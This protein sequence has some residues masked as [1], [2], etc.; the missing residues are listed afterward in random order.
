MQL[1]WYINVVMG[2]NNNKKKLIVINK[3]IN[4]INDLIKRLQND[5]RNAFDICRPVFITL[6]PWIPEKGTDW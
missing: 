2:N 3:Q 6:H 1:H 5:K 4:K